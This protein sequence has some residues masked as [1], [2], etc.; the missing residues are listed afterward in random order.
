MEFTA[1]SSFACNSGNSAALSN[2]TVET[3]KCYKYTVASS[4]NFYVGNWSGSG[5]GMT[6][7]DCGGT[8]H[9]VTVANGN[10]TTYAVGGGCEIYTEFTT[11]AGLQFDTY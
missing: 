7:T 3:N 6:Y 8:P 4:G 5:V 9:T 1:G 10:W 11:S 2:M